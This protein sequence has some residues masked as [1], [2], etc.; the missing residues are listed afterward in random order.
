MCCFSQVDLKSSLPNALQVRCLAGKPFAFVEYADHQA[1]QEAFAAASSHPILYQ[2]K[3]LKLGWAQTEG[4]TAQLGSRYGS[5][6]GDGDGVSKAIFVGG[7]SSSCPAREVEALLRSHSLSIE[8]VRKASGR[9]YAFVDF[10]SH[11]EA[12]RALALNGS[13][14]L[15]G[16]ELTLGWAMGKSADRHSDHDAECWFCL[17]SSTLKAHLIVSVGE[18]AYAALPR[19]GIVAM[20]V[21]VSPIECVPNRLHLSQ[22][23]STRPTLLSILL[24]MRMC[25]ICH[26]FEWVACSQR[27]SWSCKNM[28]QL[29]IRCS[30]ARARCHFASRG[31]SAPRGKTTCKST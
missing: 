28:S 9:E 25:E 11:E 21:M 30:L 3:E 15:E 18:H 29:S 24:Q 10:S 22:G 6:S 23:L 13:L 31:Q 4:A 12:S 8:Q 26:C 1:A 20:H 5:G 27:A 19:G 16:R 17:G 14:T 2:G 7:L